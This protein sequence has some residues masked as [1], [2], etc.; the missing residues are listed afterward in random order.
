M[1]E[2]QY[3]LEVAYQDGL[4]NTKYVSNDELLD[5]LRDDEGGYE[6]VQ[7]DV[8][9]HSEHNED[10]MEDDTQLTKT[11]YEEEND[12]DDEYISNDDDININDDHEFFEQDDDDDE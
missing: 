8:Q 1:V 11:E 10:N 5:Q 7:N 12:F 2:E 6:V 4:S 9:N 3:T